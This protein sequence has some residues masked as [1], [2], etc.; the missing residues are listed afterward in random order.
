MARSVT[1][2]VRSSPY[3][4]VV[5]HPVLRRLLPGYMVSSLG[6]GMAVV[7]V[8]WLA[9]ELAPAGDRGL[10]VALA[11]AAYTLPGAAGAVL[12][13]RLL[14]GLRP[15]R[16]ASWDALLR[17][18][19]LGAIPLAHTTGVLSIRLYVALL[20]ASS[21]LHS[22][23]Q[24]GTYTLIARQLP[25]DPRLAGNAVLS[26]IG[27]TATVTGPL[28]AA[29]L[30]VWGGAV[31]VLAVDAVTFTV[32][33]A[34][35]RLGVPP[36]ADKS[37]LD[38]A[39]QAP[40]TSGFGVIRHDRRLLSLLLLSAGF[41]LLF[42]PVYVALPLHVA[43]DLHA[44]V[45]VLATFY[46]LFGAGAVAGALL[47]GYLRRLPLGPTAAG[48]VVVSGAALLPLGLGAPTL[49]ALVGFALVGLLWPPYSSMSTTLFQHST[50]P[51]LLPQVL[52][53]VSAVRI[54][55]VPLGT[56][57]GGPAVAAFGPT[58]TLLVSAVGILALGLAAAA[59][60]PPRG[61]PTDRDRQPTDPAPKPPTT[62]HA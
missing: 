26:T 11:A 41:F 29:P 46:S 31:S 34:T 39:T 9:V 15:A 27:S 5:A 54:L 42:G 57:L 8:S 33:A 22:W 24:A 62:S 60:L 51:A 21:V 4:P 47:T 50:T 55:A 19:A 53:I 48:I 16:L 52:A 13:N 58:R 44:P 25:E 32:L 28:L 40:P 37:P 20:A 43:H 45:G 17:A 3:W 6:D 35:L 61:Q 23:G 38:G 59:A 2:A 1:H 56:L 18:C 12:L 49:A 10:W 30:I 14:R 36:D 7:A